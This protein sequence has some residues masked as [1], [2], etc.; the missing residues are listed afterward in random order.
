MIGDCTVQRLLFLY[1][2]VSLDWVDSTENGL[3]QVLDRFSEPYSA[4]GMKI[5]TIKTETIVPVQTT[6]AVLNPS[7]W[8]TTKTVRKIQVS[9]RLIHKWWQMK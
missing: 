5:R 6:K 2:L 8:S 7:W 9:R 4:A 3:Q 1:D